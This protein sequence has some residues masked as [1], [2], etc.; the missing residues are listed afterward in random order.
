MA[1]GVFGTHLAAGMPRSRGTILLFH[2]ADSNRAEYA[3]IAPEL[4]RLG[5]DS[6]AID[7]R[8]GGD[9]WGQRNQTASL[10]A[11]DPGYRAALPD[12]QAALAWARQRDATG[13]VLAWGSSYSAALIFLLAAQAGEGVS[14][15]LAFS[16]GEYLGNPPVRASA[17][18]VRCP[19]FVTN[20]ADAEEAATAGA[21]LVAVRGA[22]KRQY[23]PTIGVHGSAALRVDRNPRGAATAWAAVT[24]FLDE[25]EP[26]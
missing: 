20:A 10:L 7:Q 26:T 14:A 12:L 17:A 19:V 15:L 11:R 25:V 13:L 21:L 1:C 9:A 8:S 16:P 2:M 4:A 23:R 6:L 18:M 3:P 24:S 22:P 5:F